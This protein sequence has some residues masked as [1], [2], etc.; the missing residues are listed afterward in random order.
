MQEQHQGL[1]PCKAMT[2]SEVR[3]ICCS[4]NWGMEENAS[5]SAGVSYTMQ[6]TVLTGV[7]WKSE[8]SW[9]DEGMAAASIPGK[10]MDPE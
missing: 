2:K 9:Q 10:C 3:F 4:H 1:S 5:L 6:A 7:A 8:Q